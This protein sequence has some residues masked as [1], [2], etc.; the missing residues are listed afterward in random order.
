MMKLQQIEFTQQ[1]TCL[2]FSLLF[3]WHPEVWDA[4]KISNCL[5]QVP[6]ALMGIWIQLNIPLTLGPWIL[7]LVLGKQ[8]GP[9]VA[10]FPTAE[11]RCSGHPRSYGWVGRSMSLLGDAK[12]PGRW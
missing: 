2:I 11:V 9:S 4:A 5:P 8:A 12:C 7:T 10:L 3:L 6:A 1:V